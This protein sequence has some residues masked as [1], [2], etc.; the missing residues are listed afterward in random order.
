M[1]KWKQQDFNARK[2]IENKLANLYMVKNKNIILC[3]WLNGVQFDC[4]LDTQL[5]YF[6]PDMEGL[7][8]RKCCQEYDQWILTNEN[9][10]SKRI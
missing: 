5:I 8:I 4:R 9:Q 7:M 3:I 10:T 2:N 1:A 6:I